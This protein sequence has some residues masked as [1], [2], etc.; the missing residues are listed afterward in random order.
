VDREEIDRILRSCEAELE[1][2]VSPDLRGEGFWRVV[3]AV[4]LDPSLLDAY[5]ERIADVDRRAF[6]RW[7]YRSYPIASGQALLW[8]GTVAGLIVIA[9]GYYLGEPWNGLFLL[10][11]TGLLLLTTHGLG[12]LVVGRM[13]GIRF[14]HWFIAGLRQPQPGVKTDYASYLRAPARRRAWMHASGAL[15][16]KAV[17]FLMLGA[18]WGM[19]APAW[20]WWALIA[21]GA[22]M[23]LTDVFLS[24][25]QSDWKKFRREMRLADS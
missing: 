1:A 23:I 5:A 20:A 22:V 6:L 21:I 7:A 24:V 16:T 25:N 15:V 11:G 19:E 4:K 14:T 2:G 12:H 13:F 9:I 3:R 17:P 8:T 18:A 10:G